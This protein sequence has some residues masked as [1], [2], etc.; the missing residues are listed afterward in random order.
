MLPS[1]I[2]SSGS[3]DLRQVARARLDA[4]YCTAVSAMA[5]HLTLAELDFI[6]AQESLGKCPIDVHRALVDR[7]PRQGLA[8]PTLS[9]FRKA[10]RGVTY[11][12]SRKE[13]RGR[14]QKLSRQHVLKMDSV[15]IRVIKNAEGQRGGAIAGFFLGALGAV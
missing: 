4:P 8:A 3:F 2:T 1:A 9:R 7:R 15:R 6:Q 10:L 5:P 13:T 12:R 14:K 11:K